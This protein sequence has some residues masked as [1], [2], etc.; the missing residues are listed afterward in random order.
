MYGQFFQ[1]SF[2]IFQRDV[3]SCGRY[4]GWLCRDI[5]LSIEV[6]WLSRVDSGIS[7]GGRLSREYG[8]FSCEDPDGQV[9]LR[10]WE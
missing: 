10:G 3:F 7:V 8:N 1:D 2:R 9:L 6:L 4:A 5:W